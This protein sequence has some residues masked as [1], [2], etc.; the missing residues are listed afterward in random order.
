M[1]DRLG[2]QHD[3][4]V[5]NK[6][7]SALA[8]DAASGLPPATLFLMG[9]LAEHHRCITADARRTVAKSWRRVRGRRWRALRRGLATLESGPLASAAMPAAA[10]A[11]AAGGTNGGAAP[12][13]SHPLSH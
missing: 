7:L 6:R 4:Y 3:A 2:A 8:A 12:P 13:E 1:Q 5:A 9:R 10:P 11:A